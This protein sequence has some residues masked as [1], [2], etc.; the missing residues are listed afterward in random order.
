MSTKADEAC[1]KAVRDLCGRLDDKYFAFK[2]SFEANL[3]TMNSAQASMTRE[4]AALAKDGCGNF[5]VP[6]FSVTGL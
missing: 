2:R 5:S 3:K 4:S 6:K 1:N